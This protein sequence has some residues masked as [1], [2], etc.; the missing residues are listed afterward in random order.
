MVDQPQVESVPADDELRPMCKEWIWFLLLG[1][2]MILLGVTAVV[3][4]PLVTL[5]LA[6]VFGII[7]IVAGIVQTATAF[8]SPRWSGLLMQL[9]LGILYVVVGVLVAD[10][11]E[12]VANAFALLMAAFFIVSGIFRIVA[13]LHVR[14]PNWGW[15][16]LSGFVSLLLGLVV[17]IHWPATTVLIG[18]FVGV[19]IVF[20]GWAWVM[21][22]FMLRALNKAIRD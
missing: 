14:H 18:V 19:E 22:A 7:L 10:S 12:E 3:M 2:G 8:F 20:N 15:T 21:F 16:L 17:W 4:A 13:S 5:A 9:L 6:K 1:I 11:P